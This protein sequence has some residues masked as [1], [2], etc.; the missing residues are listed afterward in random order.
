MA[1]R[2]TAEING[3]TFALAGVL[4]FESVLAIDAEGQSWLQG[5][6]PTVC[7]INLAAVSYSSSVGI[8]LLLGWLRVALQQHKTLH[9]L[10]LPADMA[11]LARVG[12]LEEL[13]AGV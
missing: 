5:A 8:A 13:L 1:A 12:G 11:A 9:L 3:D 7:N 6:A 2:A 10:Q 4:D